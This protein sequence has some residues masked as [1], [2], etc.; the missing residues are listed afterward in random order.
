MRIA[1]KVHLPSIENVSVSI[2]V[3]AIDLELSSKVS[4][5]LGISDIEYLESKDLIKT[6]IDFEEWRELSDLLNNTIKESRS[7]L[8][9]WKGFS[10]KYIDLDEDDIDG[11][12]FV[13]TKSFHNN[14]GKEVFQEWESNL[15]SSIKFI[16]LEYNE[17][18]NLKYTALSYCNNRL[19]YEDED[20][21]ISINK[22]EDFCQQLETFF[23]EK[24]IPTIQHLKERKDLTSN[25]DN[26]NCLVGNLA[27]IK[28][29]QEKETISPK[30]VKEYLTITFGEEATQYLNLPKE[31]NNTYSL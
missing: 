16:N 31:K 3:G 6:G 5:Q 12:T 28:K 24:Y 21:N 29:I 18:D 8:Y 11:H 22:V 17:Y 23:K 4:I 19:T 27:I 1:N 30:N 26:Y 13:F 2:E 14:S 20:F 25:E 10:N 9:L 15:D 7:V